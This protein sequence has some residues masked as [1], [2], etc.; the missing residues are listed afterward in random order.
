[1][2]I[3]Y[4]CEWMRIVNQFAIYHM[5][6]LIRYK[7]LLVTFWCLNLKLSSDIMQAHKCLEENARVRQVLTFRIKNFNSTVVQGHNP[8]VIVVW[9]VC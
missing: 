6:V 2:P 1:M 7:M 8:S 3:Y 4:R 5:C 9:Q